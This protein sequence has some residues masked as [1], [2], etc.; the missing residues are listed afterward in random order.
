MTS[1]QNIKVTDNEIVVIA[2]GA[3]V[4]NDGYIHRTTQLEHTLWLLK[5]QLKTKTLK[6]VIPDGEPIVCTAFETV[7]DRIQKNHNLSPQQLTLQIV[8]C[9]PPYKN[10]RVTVT[11]VPCYA[12]KY[13]EPLQSPNWIM[14]PDPVLFGGIYGRFNL[15]RFLMSYFLETEF[16][17][18]S[19]VIFQPSLDYLL[20]EIDPV[21]DY[22]TDQIA[23]AHQRKEQNRTYGSYDNGSPTED[24][25]QAT[26]NYEQVWKKYKIEIICEGNLVDHGWFTEKTAR[27]LRTKKP[28]L[29]LGTPGQLKKLQDMGFKTFAE[30]ID[31]NYDQIQNLDDRFDA[32]TKE[33]T[34]IGTLS[35]SEL[36]K[37]FNHANSIAQYNADNYSQIVE[38]YYQS[39]NDV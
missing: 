34:R 30:C 5:D 39:F 22:Y 10:E 32:I 11:Q 37:F 17:D 7:I 4:K 15:Y 13:V 35:Q 36:D 1:M 21:K 18:Q 24:Y 33:I 12:F 28:F 9:C 31:E 14:N 16:P 38:K 2:S 25:D 8:D 3:F 26:R 29:L 19:F 23:W 6:I 20:F 27:C